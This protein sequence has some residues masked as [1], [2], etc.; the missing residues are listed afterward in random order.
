MDRE[1]ES[2]RKMMPESGFVVVD[3]WS[4]AMER[5]FGWPGVSETVI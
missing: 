5:S 1:A 4:R 3:I 2:R